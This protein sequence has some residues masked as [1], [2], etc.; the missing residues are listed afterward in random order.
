MQEKRPKKA[1]TAIPVPATE[2]YNKIEVSEQSVATPRRERQG[3]A[4]RDYLN[5][6][7]GLASVEQRGERKI[8]DQI[9]EIG[10][11]CLQRN[12]NGSLVKRRY[13]HR[14]G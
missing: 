4:A 14:Q 3:S 10:S 8:L 9:Q 7:C 6:R 13:P 11:L 5:G 12:S 1:K 2:D